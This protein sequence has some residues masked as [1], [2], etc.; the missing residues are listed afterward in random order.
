MLLPHVISPQELVPPGSQF[1]PTRDVT[2]L[3][4]NTVKLGLVKL[5]WADFGDG[6]GYRA[7]C[8]QPC[9]LASFTGGRT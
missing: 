4:S 5:V 3:C 9:F 7:V 1:D 6:F 2:C 8:A